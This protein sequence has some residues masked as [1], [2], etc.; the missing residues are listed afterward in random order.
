VSSTTE[1]GSSPTIAPARPS[2]AGTSPAAG[3]VLPAQVTSHGSSTVSPGRTWSSDDVLARL[4]AHHGLTGL[5]VA[6]LAVLVLAP[7][8]S[9][10]LAAGGSF[11]LASSVFFVL[12]SLAGAL[13]ARPSALASAAVLPP[14]LFTGSV[15]TLAWA[16]GDNEGTRQLGLDVGTTLALS[17]PL[18]FAT[19]AA[20]LVVVL[21]RVAVRL[22]RR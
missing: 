7:G 11:G 6:V 13:A 3:P 21:A 10:D 14:L 18:L 15:A 5:G 22:A 2:V 9:V 16:S 19:T 12:A 4:R 17:A 20:T 1:T 8:V